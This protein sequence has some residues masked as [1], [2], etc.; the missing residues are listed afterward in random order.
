MKKK[1]LD[2]LPGLT[3][4]GTKGETG[5]R[6]YT[7]FYNYNESY[8][9]Y[10]K[11]D[12]TNEVEYNTKTLA[13]Y[14]S[15]DDGILDSFVCIPNM[16]LS[17]IEHD[18][19]LKTEE[20]SLTL[21][22][23]SQVIT[24]DLVKDDIYPLFSS[25]NFSIEDLEDYIDNKESRVYIVETLVKLIESYYNNKT[26]SFDENILNNLEYLKEYKICIIEKLDTLIYEKSRGNS[27]GFDELEVEIVSKKI[28]YSDW[29]KTY[30]TFDGTDDETG[31]A[32]IS[33]TFEIIDSIVTLGDDYNIPSD[34]AASSDMRQNLESLNIKIF[35]AVTNQQILTPVNVQAY[36]YAD[37]STIPTAEFNKTEIGYSNLDFASLIN[38]KTTTIGELEEYEVTY[39]TGEEY[40][41]VAKLLKINAGKDY[42][43][44]YY[45]L[46][47]SSVYGKRGCLKGLEGDSNLDLNVYV[48][49]YTG[50]NVVKNISVTDYYPYTSTV[51]PYTKAY[52]VDEYGVDILTEQTTD[53]MCISFSVFSNMSAKELE[54]LAVIANFIKRDNGKKVFTQ[55]TVTNELW[56]SPTAEGD[57]ITETDI[58]NSASN[59][60]PFGLIGNYKPG[61]NFD[62]EDLGDFT[63][64]IKYFDEGN[65]QQTYFSE[66]IVPESIIENYDIELY[67][68]YKTSNAAYQKIYLGEAALEESVE[69]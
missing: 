58:I 1:C 2:G 53:F 50:D 63:I 15:N 42:L 61:M 28:S 54:K 41:I 10:I 24:M 44:S 12:K 43:T 59:E 22:E 9:L 57:S 45:L 33:T 13:F 69:E 37:M 26:R 38:D 11:N 64:F 39:D 23:I 66:Q 27:Q 6:G 49:P 5:K 25:G 19:L 51:Y 60:H 17:P 67:A 14:S 31:E 7:T 62:E 36:T 56:D 29:Q 32:A 46:E 55:S 16:Q 18:R 65:D 34:Y 48:M 35:D 30:K 21:Y 3:M 8:E 68:Y 20:D 4:Q 40:P 52:V 47:D